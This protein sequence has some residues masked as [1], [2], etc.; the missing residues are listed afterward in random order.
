[1]ASKILAFLQLF[2][3]TFDLALTAAF[4][5]VSLFAQITRFWDTDFPEIPTWDAPDVNGPAL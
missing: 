2:K 5:I 1:M 3:E 4:G